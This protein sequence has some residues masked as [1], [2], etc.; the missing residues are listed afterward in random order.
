MVDGGIVHPD[1]KKRKELG[2]FETP[3]KYNSKEQEALSK[4]KLVLISYKDKKSKHPCYALVDALYKTLKESS[5]HFPLY[6][7]LIFNP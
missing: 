2:C 5:D 3:P 6:S 1:F 4:K 7:T